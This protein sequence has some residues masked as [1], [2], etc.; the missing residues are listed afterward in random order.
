MCVPLQIIKSFSSGKQKGGDFVDCFVSPQGHWIDCLAEDG[1]VYCFST[2][3]G[4]LEH[5]LQAH[6]KDVIGITHHPHYNLVATYANDSCLR[7]WR[8]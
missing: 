5:V 2:Q 3:S 6:Q 4:Q 8:P 1:R 7:L